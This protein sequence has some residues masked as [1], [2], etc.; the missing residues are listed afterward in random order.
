LRTW[1]VYL[2]ELLKGQKLHAAEGDVM[3]RGGDVLIDPD[4]IVRLHHVGTGPADRPAVEAI[5]TRVDSSPKGS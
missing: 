1:R 4:G 2:R 5:L 3:Q